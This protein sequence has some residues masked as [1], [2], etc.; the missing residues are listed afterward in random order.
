M[1]AANIKNLHANLSKIHLIVRALSHGDHTSRLRYAL[2]VEPNVP[3]YM[4][5]EETFLQATLADCLA[6]A[7]KDTSPPTRMR[8]FGGTPPTPPPVHGPA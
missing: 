2:S 5:H 4:L 8:Y 7:T 6:P 1:F 3:M